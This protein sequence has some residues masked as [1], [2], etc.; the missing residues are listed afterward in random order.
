MASRFASI[1]PMPSETAMFITPFTRVSSGRTARSRMTDFLPLRARLTFQTVP[2][3]TN[4]RAFCGLA[5]VSVASSPWS[6][7]AITI[8]ARALGNPKPTSRTLKTI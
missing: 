4:S 8:R 6:S 7:G 2:L 1:F 5:S 3:S